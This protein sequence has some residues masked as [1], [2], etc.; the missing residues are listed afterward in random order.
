MKKIIFTTIVLLSSLLTSF[1]QTC[2]AVFFNQEGD[3]FQ[4]V[5]NGILQNSDFQTN[6]KI[7]GLAN[8]G[9]FKVKILFENQTLA[10]LDKSIYT[11]ENNHEYNYEI[12]K[13]NKGEYVM[14]A[15]SFY[16]LQQ[17]PPPAPTQQ[18][19]VY[20]VTPPPPVATSSTVIVSET[21]TTTVNSNPNYNDNVNMNMNMGGLGVGMNVNINV[22][23]N[24]GQTTQHSQ[25]VTTTSSSSMTTNQQTMAPAPA[26]APTHYVMQGYNGPIGCNWPMSPEDFSSAKQSISSKSFEDSKLTLAKQVFNTN[27]LTSSQVRE[28]M[29]LFSFEDSRLDFAKFAYNRTFDTGNYFKVNDAFQFE[30]SIDDLNDY[31]QGGR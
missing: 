28:I 17:A 20:S 31:I 6:V 16:P 27:C 5:L 15:S 24:M 7:T 4:V 1:S 9:S 26:P 22:N 8:Q 21:T 19:I 30:S 23:D 12:K 25:T 10:P 13:N 2:N 14:R 11:M 29:G 18:V 3:R